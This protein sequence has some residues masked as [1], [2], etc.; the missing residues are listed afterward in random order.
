MDQVHIAVRAAGKPLTIF[1][2]ALRAEHDAESLQLVR[3]NCTEASFRPS[4]RAYLRTHRRYRG[5][6]AS[7]ISRTISRARP[8]WADETEMRVPPSVCR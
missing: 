5:G 4:V 8:S 7:V 2:F 3:V 1:R 6:S